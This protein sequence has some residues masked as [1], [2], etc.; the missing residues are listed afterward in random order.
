A[1]ATSCALCGALTR[2]VRQTPT[3][4]PKKNRE[5]LR[6]LANLLA[7]QRGPITS[8]L[9]DPPTGHDNLVSLRLPNSDRRLGQN[10]LAGA[11]PTAKGQSLWTASRPRS[12]YTR[13]EAF[14]K[15]E[16]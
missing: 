12:E 6:I 3:A 11:A 14:E 13:S 8:C 16:F 7:V 2:S 4:A 9:F 5:L 15:Q 1:V 10:R